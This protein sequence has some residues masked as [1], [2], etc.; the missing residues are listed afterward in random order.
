MAKILK[1]LFYIETSALQDKTVFIVFIFTVMTFFSLEIAKHCFFVLHFLKNALYF[2]KL[3]KCVE[4]L[5]RVWIY[6]TKIGE[7]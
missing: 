3:F 6:S 5:F 2:C 7:L 4:F 1:Y